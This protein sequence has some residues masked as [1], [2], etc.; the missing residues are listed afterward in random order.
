MTPLQSI[1]CFSSIWSFWP[2]KDGR[3]NSMTGFK[4][5]AT[6][7]NLNGDLLINCAKAYL[8]ETDPEFCH[9]LGN[10]MRDGHYQAYCLAM[11][12]QELDDLSKKYDDSLASAIKLIE[13]WN[14]SAGLCSKFNPVIAIEDRLVMA[15]K[16][17]RNK[18]F[19][20]N[21]TKAL[22]LL[23]LLMQEDFSHDDPRTYIKPTLQWFCQ[24]QYDKFSVAKIIEGDYGKPSKKYKKINRKPIKEEP[25]DFD[26]EDNALQFFQNL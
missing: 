20:E 11:S 22:R 26:T 10:W 19:Y 25:S 5:I 18:F 9:Q 13:N 2:N 14:L 24:T 6:E 17:M 3:A 12:K 7:G 4:F 21:N 23:F 16:A 8:Y 15:K 1:D